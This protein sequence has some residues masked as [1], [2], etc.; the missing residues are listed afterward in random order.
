M[1]S[2]TGITPDFLNVV[3]KGISM[4]N[5]NKFS[6]SSIVV[7]H[8]PVYKNIGEQL[9]DIRA[10]SLK[11]SD[12]PAACER[13]QKVV[14]ESGLK[15]GIDSEGGYLVET[16]KAQEI[17][18][19]SVEAGVLSSRCAEQ[20]IGP[21]SDS[22]EYYAAN[23][24]DLSQG[25]LFGGVKTYRK[26]E[27]EEMSKWAAI[28]LDDREVRLNDQFA[29]L[30]VTNRTLKDNIALNSMV[31]KVIPKAFAFMEDKEIFEGTGAGQHLGIM[32]S[33]VLITIAKE[34]SQVTKTIVAQNIVNMFARFGGDI[35][36]AA[37]FVNQDCTTQFPFMTVDTTSLFVP[38]AS[39]LG[40]PY[41]TLYGLPIIPIEHCETLGTKGDIVL[42]DFSQ[43]LR[44]TKGGVEEAE[45]IH[46]R[47]L[48]G[49]RVFR[50]IKRNN[51]Q[52][53]HNKPIT[54][55]KGSDTRSPF[56]ALA[57]RA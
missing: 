16:D 6:A 18:Q 53:I 10:I 38:N 7:E 28:D 35:T 51:G 3:K 25:L 33:D 4:K 13:F 17:I 41:G 11:N 9:L 15:T 54:P 57:G 34:S 48:T 20:P 29:L 56:V 47:F 36:T 2:T 24:R 32:N 42:G 5:S 21:N 22:F 39:S 8:K 23:D 27:V 46:V 44:I 14:N 30:K 55:L 49:E 43:Y 45:S 31:K 40:T 26:S 1:E 12:A 19:T 37:W 50:F 52:P